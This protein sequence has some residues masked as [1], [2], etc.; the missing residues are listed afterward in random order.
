MVVMKDEFSYL[1][2]FADFLSL[3]T[4]GSCLIL[5]VPQILNLLRVKNAQGMN[6]TGL[7]LELTR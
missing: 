4:I 3:I 2:A 5:K 6:L 7:L 1:Q